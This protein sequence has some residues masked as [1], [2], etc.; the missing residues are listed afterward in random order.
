MDSIKK[1]TLEVVERDPSHQTL[2]R[3]GRLVTEEGIVFGD[4]LLGEGLI[5][6]LGPDLSQEAQGAEI[7]EAKGSFVIPG[8]ID[9]HTHMEL[10]QSP[11]HRS[12]DDFFQGSVAAALGGTTTL[13]DHIGFGPAGCP[14]HY[15]IDRYREKGKKAAVDYAFHGVL[16]HVNESIL[17]ELREIIQ[18]EGIP[19]FKAYS[20]YA[21]PLSDHD[22]FQAL[23]VM[24]EAKGLLTMHCENDAV[25]N[26]LKKE[27]LAR[28]NT[29]PIWQART[30]PAACEKESISRL[31]DLSALSGGAPIYIV[32]TSTQ[33]GVAAIQ[34]GRAR[35]IPVAMETCP[36]YLLLQEGAYTEHGPLEG[37]KYLMAPP[38]R[39][40]AD[41][42]ALWES[43]ADG[44]CDTVATDHCPFPLEEKKVGE[45]NF[46]LAPGGCAGV[47]ERLPLIYTHGVLPGRISLERM[48]ALLCTNPA[49]IMGLYP[50][51]GTLA[52][53][54]DAD[55]V[56]L[57]PGSN[58][59]IRA[60][61]QATTCDYSIYEGWGNRL[62]IHRVISRGETIVKEGVFLGE[63][64]RG[65]FLKRWL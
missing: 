14:L 50:Q 40:P 9:V 1:T 56:V 11:E 46:S 58:R 20:T 29:E 2:V 53:G 42:E 51:K 8:A 64:G 23:R 47:Q 63:R 41:Q 10:Q 54:S 4:L 45:K 39:S 13:I 52:V 27:A 12:C 5:L 26:L 22:L 7:I 59:P 36:Q 48:V 3:G 31:I 34:A 32:H 25:T 28:G 55:L 21:Y 24:K 15:A 60:K 44:T 18:T 17:N 38:L 16:Q 43:L 19:S 61:E 57:G 30:R 35:G 37:L 49:K 65:R 62:R 33:E 6:A